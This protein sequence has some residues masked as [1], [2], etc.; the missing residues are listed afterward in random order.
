MNA[1]IPIRKFAVR[2][3]VAVSSRLVCVYCDENVKM[4][5]LKSQA[6]AFP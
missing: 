3:D 6:I 4:R 1:F 2:V 5:Y